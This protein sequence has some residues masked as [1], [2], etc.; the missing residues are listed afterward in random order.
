[1]K[2]Q[3]TL[4]ALA[5]IL[6]MTGWLAGGAGNVADARSADTVEGE[7][8]MF[9]NSAGGEG[10]TGKTWLYSTKSGKVYRVWEGCNPSDDDDPGCLEAVSLSKVDPKYVYLPRPG[11]EN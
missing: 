1:M 10:Y 5:V 8:R 11:E 6:L 3:L 9:S 2:T 4:A 7:W